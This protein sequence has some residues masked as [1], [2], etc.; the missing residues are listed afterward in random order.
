MYPVSVRD[1]PGPEHGVFCILI[2]NLISRRVL[3]L[4]SLL[5]A[6][7]YYYSKGPVYYVL[8]FNSNY[9][10]SELSILFVFILFQDTPAWVHFLLLFIDLQR[11]CYFHHVLL[12]TITQFCFTHKCWICSFVIFLNTMFSERNPQPSNFLI[13]RNVVRPQR[14]RALLKVSRSKWG[15]H[16]LRYK[17]F[18]LR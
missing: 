18:G 8:T 2:V 4:F 16:W 11:F 10:Y 5:H 7:N 17:L 14:D 15:S 9:G 1:C 6:I 12:W 3:V 13:V